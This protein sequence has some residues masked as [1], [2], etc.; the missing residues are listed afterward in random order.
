[1]LNQD[2]HTSTGMLLLRQGE[3]LTLTMIECLMSF[4][5]SFGIPEPLNILVPRAASEPEPI[6]LP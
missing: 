2:V 6:D 3:E 4:S 5:R 1:L